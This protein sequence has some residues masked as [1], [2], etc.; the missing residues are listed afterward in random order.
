MLVSQ[1][2]PGQE[3]GNARLVAEAGAGALAT[4]AEAIT[5]AVRD[6]TADG[7]AL[8]SQWHA[9]AQSLGHPHAAREIAEWIL[10][11]TPS[12]ALSP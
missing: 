2:V 4:N 11:G 5:Q 8:W 7:G 12:E 3:E 6:A 10:A 1:V 9:A